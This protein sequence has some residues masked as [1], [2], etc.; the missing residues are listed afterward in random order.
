MSEIIIATIIGVGGT[1]L[2]AIVSVITQ[3]FI[4]RSVI[5]SE[6]E[7]IDLGEKSRVREKRIDRIIDAISELL[8]TSDP[9]SSAG[10]DYGRT[11]NLISRVQ[12]LLDLSEEDERILNNSLNVL[13]M[14]LHEYHPVRSKYIDDKLTETKALL[15]AH[16]QVIEN[17]RI[18]LLN[19]NKTNQ[20]AYKKLS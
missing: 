5:N 3:L 1:V 10:V 8:I 12:L 14:S 17:T 11:A 7:K 4:T 19:Y 2:V 18:F 20:Q 16:S 6:K 15:K 9:Q 13:G